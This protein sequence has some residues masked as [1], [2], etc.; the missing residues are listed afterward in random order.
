MLGG[1]I[2]SSKEKKREKGGKKW[3]F[4]CWSGPVVQLFCILGGS[5]SCY[6][7]MMQCKEPAWHEQFTQRIEKLMQKLIHRTLYVGYVKHVDN[8]LLCLTS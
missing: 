7:E 5:R 6:H 1:K 8:S 3:L 4:M 2:R